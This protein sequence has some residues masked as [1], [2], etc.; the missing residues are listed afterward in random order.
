MLYSRHDGNKASP[1][2]QGHMKNVE[3]G[4]PEDSEEEYV[5]GTLN[6][7]WP[8]ILNKAETINYSTQFAEC[9]E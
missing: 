1:L 7:I 3:E 6:S 9:G 2:L 8:A 4:Y 5:K